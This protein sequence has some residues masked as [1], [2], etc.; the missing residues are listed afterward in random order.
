VVVVA[1]ELVWSC[2][3]VWIILASTL[4]LNVMLIIQIL[5]GFLGLMLGL[6]S[7]PSIFT[8]GL[9]QLVDFSSSDTDES[10]LRESMANSLAFL[11]LSVFPDLHGSKAG[12]STNRFMAEAAS[13]VG[14][15][16]LVVGV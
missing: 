6:F 1:T 10:F 9:S 15:L 11:A 2:T 8:L 13:V 12:S 3:L 16:N 5:S 4:A 7:V 14:L